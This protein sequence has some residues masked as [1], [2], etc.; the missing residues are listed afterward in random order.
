MELKAG[1]KL[2][3]YEIQS[4]LGAGGMREVYRAHDTRLQRSIAIKVLKVRRNEDPLLR[5]RIQ[6]EAVF[7]PMGTSAAQKA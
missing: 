2:G 4:P 6:A 3:P 7:P 5:K 1:A